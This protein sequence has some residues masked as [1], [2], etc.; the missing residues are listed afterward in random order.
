M[1][2]IN[3]DNPMRTAATAVLLAICL[4][5]GACAERMNRDD[6]AQLIKGKTE[7]E[8]MKNTGKPT[9]VDEKSDKHVWTYAART[10]DVANQNKMD[11]KALV[12]FTPAPE[13][14]KWVV[15]EVKFE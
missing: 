9:S 13:G 7:Q 15:A 2:R 6:F 4:A 8:V 10:F 3:L 1:F 14:G 11:S 5:V 12:I